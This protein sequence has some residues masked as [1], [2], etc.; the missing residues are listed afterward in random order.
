MK[1]DLD[2]I[3]E[4][5]KRRRKRKARPL[6]KK[7]EGIDRR[8]RGKRWVILNRAT[9]HRFVIRRKDNKPMPNSPFNRR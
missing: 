1:F 3:K 8:K 5:I 6:E 4:R 7:K 2:K 9:G